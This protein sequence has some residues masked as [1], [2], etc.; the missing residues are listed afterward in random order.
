MTLLI[1]IDGNIYKEN[2]ARISVFDRGFLYGDSIYEVIRSYGE[3]TFAMEEHLRRLQRSADLLN[4]ELPV[5]AIRLESEIRRIISQAGNR[6]SY[7]RIII[8]RG[9]GEITL[10]PAMAVN[11]HYVIICKEY[12]APPKHLYDEGASVIL[13]GSGKLMDSALPPGSKS[14]NYLVNLMALAKAKQKG[15][16]EAIL[17]DGTGKVA[18]GTTCNFFIVK[19]NMVITPSLETGILA[20]I[21]RSIIIELCL[22]WNIPVKEEDLHQKDLRNAD[23]TFLTSTIRDVMPVTI[24]DEMPVK[25]GRPGPVTDNLRRAYIEYVKEYI[26]KNKN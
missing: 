22:R 26:S 9:E 24:I 10:D 7:V 5:P 4:M 20:G 3:V 18:E 2:E 21:T 16:Y 14:G 1:N 17:V 19:N 15:S 23:E 12:Q 13:V 25:N 11:P 6:D 8:T